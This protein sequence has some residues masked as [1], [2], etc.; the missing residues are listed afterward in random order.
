NRDYEV[1]RE[2]YLDL[3]ERRESAKLGQS[4]DQSASDVTF[5][6]IEPPIVPVLASGPN[7]L[8]L[9]TGVLLAALAAGLG[10]S[11][12][13][14]LLQ[15]TYIN[16]QQ[17]RLGT[18]LPVLGSVSLYL[19]PEHRKIRQKQLASFLSATALLL[20][21]YGGTIYSVLT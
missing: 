15:P 13:Q 19:T 21:V 8:L 6:I 11:Y 18:G 20:C 9:M 16:M 14:N 5:R 2:R 7:R 4:A 1:T 3:V 12:L 10:W 17:V